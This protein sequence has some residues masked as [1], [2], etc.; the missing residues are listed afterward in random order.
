MTPDEW[1]M[2][3]FEQIFEACRI[4]VE[5][6][7]DLWIDSDTVFVRPMFQILDQPDCQEARWPKP[8]NDIDD[9]MD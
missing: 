7:G 5:G 6:Y 3:Q 9:W 8:L 2:T 4:E 1:L